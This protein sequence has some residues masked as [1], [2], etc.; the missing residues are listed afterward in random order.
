MK[1]FSPHQILQVCTLLH[2]HVLAEAVTKSKF[3]GIVYRNLRSTSQYL[4]QFNDYLLLIHFRNI[5]GLG[6]ET[7]HKKSM[8]WPSWFLQPPGEDGY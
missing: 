7:C 2:I 8:T 4:I 1:N 3:E 5:L 6:L